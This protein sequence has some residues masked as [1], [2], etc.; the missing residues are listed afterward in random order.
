ME[1][2]TKQRN[3]R[4]AKWLAENGG[5]CAVCHTGPFCPACKSPYWSRERIHKAIA[6]ESAEHK[7]ATK[8]QIRRIVADHEKEAEAIA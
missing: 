7:W 8:K 1:D 6:Q 5:L 2:T 4:K 3:E